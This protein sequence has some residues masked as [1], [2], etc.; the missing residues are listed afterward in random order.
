VYK[1]LYTKVNACLVTLCVAACALYMVGLVAGV[2]IQ[3]VLRFSLLVGIFLGCYVNW[4]ARSW[5]L[6]VFCVG[7]SV[8]VLVVASVLVIEKTQVDFDLPR[9]DAIACYY[10]TSIA[11]AYCAFSAWVFRDKNK[12]RG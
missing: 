12:N 5:Q 1:D 8:I 9:A 7:S 6:L 3:D 2:P 4:R 10:A 11:M